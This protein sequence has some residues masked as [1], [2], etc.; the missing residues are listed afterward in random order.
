MR[1]TVGDG[2]D[3]GAERRSDDVVVIVLQRRICALSANHEQPLVAASEAAAM[4]F[5]CEF[6]GGSIRNNYQICATA[7]SFTTGVDKISC[8]LRVPC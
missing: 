3:P 1:G 6:R 7:S 4:W 8:G 2:K 5:P